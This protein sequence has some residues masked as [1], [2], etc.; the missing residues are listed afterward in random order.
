MGKTGIKYD[1]NKPKLSLLS[2]KAINELGRVLTFGAK[3]YGRYNWKDLKDIEDRC[4][5]A[6]LRHLMEILDGNLIDEE[7]GLSHYAHVMCN[8]MFLIDGGNNGE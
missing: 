4:L 6:S 5:S 1:K 2:G 7:T 8:M 3:K